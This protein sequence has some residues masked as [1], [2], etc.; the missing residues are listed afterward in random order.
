M[1]TLKYVLLILFC[2][3]ISMS[4]TKKEKINLESDFIKIEIPLENINN[5]GWGSWNTT[6]CLE[7][8]DFR[9]RNDGYN[10]YAKKTRWSIEFRNRYRE[11]IH[12]S[13]KAVSPGEKYEIKKSGKTTDRIHVNGNSGTYKTYYLVKSNSSVYVYVNKVRIGAKDYG[14][15]YYSCDK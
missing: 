11:K 8:L 14:Y 6:D 10:K 5:Q 3:F 7:G 13:Y 12:L 9:V 4:F 2:G 1:K 15:D